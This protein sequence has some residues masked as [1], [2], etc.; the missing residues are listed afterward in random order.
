MNCEH[1][2]G[3]E[4]DWKN[5]KPCSLCKDKR[6]TEGGVKTVASLTLQMLGHVT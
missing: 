2:K 6:T 5:M 4:I 1:R 3:Y